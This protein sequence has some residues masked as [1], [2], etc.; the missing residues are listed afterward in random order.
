MNKTRGYLLSLGIAI[1]MA[2]GCVV[3]VDDTPD[4]YEACSGTGGACLGGTTC[5]SSPY[6]TSGNPAAFCT[7]TCLPGSQCP[8][9][10]ARPTSCVV[11]A[12][13]AQGTCFE[14]CNSNIDC[15]AGMAC[16]DIGGVR[17]C[18][19]SNGAP[20]G[21]TT[22]QPYN[23]CPV[24]NGVCGGGSN[25]MQSLFQFPGQP[26]GSTCTAICPGGD[27]RMCPG[28]VPGQ[29]ECV[30]ATGNPAMFMCVRLC[31]DDSQCAPFGTRCGMVTLGGGV[32]NRV[33]IP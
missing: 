10:L 2:T 12:G 27:A 19:P 33:C 28:Y 31:T 11:A 22:L 1:T 24:T 15:R 3:E 4:Q 23:R 21:P 9:N 7:R 29:V 32:Q 17:I 25:C 30:N 13:S 5:L 6:T 20:A 8:S 18:I 16:G 14:N 26:Q